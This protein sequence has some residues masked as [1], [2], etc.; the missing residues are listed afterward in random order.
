M[1]MDEW[2]G[3]RLKKNEENNNSNHF[4][5]SEL[6]RF[7]VLWL[8]DNI[9]RSHSSAAFCQKGCKASIFVQCSH[10]SWKHLKASESIWQ[11]HGFCKAQQLT[12]FDV[13]IDSDMTRSLRR[14]SWLGLDLHRCNHPEAFPGQAKLKAWKCGQ[15]AVQA[16]LELHSRPYPSHGNVT[17]DHFSIL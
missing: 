13:E 5:P 2:L 12:E 1:K 6:R 8:A 4:V 3:W 10:T 15:C 7:V 14:N 9:K 16:P 11:P 17:L